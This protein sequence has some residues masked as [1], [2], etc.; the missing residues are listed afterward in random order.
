MAKKKAVDVEFTDENI[1]VRPLENVLGEG[2]LQYSEYIIKDRS[3]PMVEDGLKPVQRRI[4]YSMMELGLK[5]NVPY[6][7]SARVVGD[8]LG[9]YHPHGDTSV[10]DA[11]VRMAQSFTMRMPLVDG[12]GN[13]GSIDGDSAAAMR[14]TEARMAPLAMELLRDIDKD[15]VPWRD[16]FDGSLK[17]PEVLPSKFPNILIN[18]AA[19][20]AIG[21]ATNIP[22]HNFTEVVDGCIAYIDNPNI[23]IEEMCTIIKGPDFPT[24][25]MIYCDDMCELY[26]NG[27]G[28]IV[29]RSKINVENTDGDK[30]NIVVTEIPFNAN[31][32]SMLKKIYALKESKKELFG[33]IVDVVD[34]SDR[35]GMRIVIKL[36]KGESAEKIINNLL[37]FSD[38]QTNYSVNMTVIANGKP[39]QLGVLGILSHYLRHQKSVIY[40]RS[41]YELKI[42]QKREHIVDGYCL[43]L[44]AIDE[45]IAI[46]R[47]SPNREQSRKS[48]IERFDLTEAQAEAILSLQL[49]NI[50][51]MD[52]NKFVNELKELRSTI[53][54]LQKIIGSDAEQYNVVKEE[55]MEV[56]DNYRS[57][58]MSTVVDELKDIQVKALAE[59]KKTNKRAYIVIDSFGGIKQVSVRNFGMALKNIES[60]GIDGLAKSVSLC[61]ANLEVLVFGNKGNCYKVDTSIIPEKKWTER[62]ASLSSI[63]AG[64]TAGEKAVFILA[65]DKVTVENEDMYI[66][67]KFG[68]VKRSKVASNIINKPYYQVMGLKDDD[69]VIGGDIVQEDCTVLFISSDGQCVNTLPEYPIQ[70]SR[71]ACGVIGMSLNDG[72]IAILAKQ[73]PPDNE[74]DFIDIVVVTDKGLGKRT[75]TTEFEPMKRARKGVRI[76]DVAVNDSKAVF[77]TVVKEPTELAIIDDAGELTS[78]ETDMIRPEGRSTKGKPI[79]K[80]VKISKII[81]HKEQNS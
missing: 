26:K 67:T 5:P 28:K 79:A 57:S 34:E 46:I 42:A 20:I 41:L 47:S 16:N 22:P 33:G 37:K 25:A 55:L 7:K 11:M 23:S 54:R 62:G 77:A 70:G 35:N 30:Q 59:G 21:I 10:Y 38:L 80:G 58:R 52:V 39:E 56:R 72:E 32:I 29:I 6:K 76:I 1:V 43:I 69:E 12:H 81:A 17:E 15:T 19:G 40:R 71:S 9:K 45:V 44:P 13:F 65:C 48:L 36:R 60:S 73:L 49:G 8:C 64:A 61:E 24:G 31:K 3:L 78:I 75:A 68:N 14:Y 4:L 18:G 74:E 27:R 53:K 51:K 63:Y 2:M 66:Y 50:N